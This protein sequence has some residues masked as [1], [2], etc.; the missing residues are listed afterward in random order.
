MNTRKNIKKLVLYLTRRCNYRCA[1]CLW[2]LDDPNFFSK[3]DMSL[4]KAK[5]LLRFYREKGTWFVTLQAE[6]EALVYPWYEEIVKYATQIGYKQN[7]VTNGL[8]I[9]KFI[10][11]L[12]DSIEDITVSIDGHDAE[13]YV[14]YRGGTEKQFE[15]I[16]SNVRLR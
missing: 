5:E 14:S 11:V 6:G 3:T 9:D 10:D 7:L 15:H 8:L 12:R 1:N 2:I 13:T 4:D 16:L